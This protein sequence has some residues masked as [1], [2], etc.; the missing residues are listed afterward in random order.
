MIAGD[1]QLASCNNSVINSN[2]S[3]LGEEKKTKQIR[4]PT[5]V[6]TTT[7][8]SKGAKAVVFF[9]VAFIRTVDSSFEVQQGVM[10][11]QS[12]ENVHIFHA[13]KDMVDTRLL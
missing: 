6:A 9:A 11:S 1:E 7:L 13:S 2:N 5:S 4:Q 10:K 3:V 12:A 8:I